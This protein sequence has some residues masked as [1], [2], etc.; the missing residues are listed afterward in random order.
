MSKKRTR[1]VVAMSGG[2]D[3]SVAA[4]LLVE[5]GYDVIGMMLRLW[6][7]PGQESSNRCCTPTAM[8]L[9]RQV[10]SKLNI[11]F[12]AIDAKEIFRNHV[13]DHFIDGYTQGVTPNPCLRCNHHIRWGFL[14]NKAIA[15]DADFLATGHYAHI[16]YNKNKPVQ[17]FQAKDKEKDQ[18][19]VLGSLNQEQLKRTLFPI[20][21]HTKKIVRKKAAQI[22]LPVAEIKDSQ[23]LCFLGGTDYRSFLK[24]HST[25]VEKPGPIIDLTGNYIGEHNGLPFYTIGQRKGLGI[26]SSH[27]LY[28]IQKDVTKNVLTVGSIDELGSNNLLASE[29]NWVSGNVP[30]KSFKALIKIRYKAPPVPGKVTPID[31]TTFS[32]KFETQL[33]D[34]TPGQAAVIYKEEEVIASGIINREKTLSIELLPVKT[35]EKKL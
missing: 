26:N 8:S 21:K 16:E 2:V 13:V 17:L 33:R 25:G 35:A 3:S 10:C 24:R 6:S 29:V 9:A 31:N 4:A 1:V 34:I 27:P 23:D 12:Y 15:L 32:I 14:L 18:S 19:Y 28:V 5:Q 30:A 20:G 22:N 11:P 7:E